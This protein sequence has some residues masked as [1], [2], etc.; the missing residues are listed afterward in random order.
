MQRDLIILLWLL[1]VIHNSKCRNHFVLLW[2]LN[3]K[4]SF[5]IF[6][7]LLLCILNWSVKQYVLG[8]KIINTLKAL[9]FHHLLWG[10]KEWN[11]MI[12]NFSY[13]QKF[14]SCFTFLFLVSTLAISEIDVACDIRI[15]LNFQRKKLFKWNNHLNRRKTP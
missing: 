1:T 7:K 6:V 9:F 4:I 8:K 11:L 15:L 10:I 13:S 5:I 12:S 3:P 2:I 14:L